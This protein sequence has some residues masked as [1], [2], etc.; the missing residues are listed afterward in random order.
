MK[1]SDTTH[2]SDPKSPQKTTNTR[3]NGNSMEKE[4]YNYIGLYDRLRI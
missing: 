1:T 2:S 4:D 3:I